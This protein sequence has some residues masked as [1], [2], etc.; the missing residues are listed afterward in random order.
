MEDGDEGE[1]GD[2]GD[3]GE[4]KVNVVVVSNFSMYELESKGEDGDELGSWKPLLFLEQ[5]EEKD[6]GTETQH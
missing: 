3:E 4:D 5:G 2:T 6:L 1:D